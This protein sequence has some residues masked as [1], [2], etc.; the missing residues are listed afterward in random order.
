[1][2]IR[3]RQHDEKMQRR[4]GK[5]FVPV[6]KLI[7]YEEMEVDSRDCSGGIDEGKVV[8]KVLQHTRLLHDS[9]YKKKEEEHIYDPVYPGN[10]GITN[11][12]LH[13][14]YS[15]LYSGGS[16]GSAF[17]PLA[18]PE[19]GGRNQSHYSGREDMS[20]PL[21]P[22]TVTNFNSEYSR[23][24]ESGFQLPLSSG[25]S[26]SNSSTGIGDKMT[27]H[28]SN[29]NNYAVGTNAPLKFSKISPDDDWER[30][31]EKLNRRKAEMHHGTQYMHFV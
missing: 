2:D 4:T 10:D 16:S 3:R 26:S 31:K 24:S 11:G 25:G 7:D 9:R 17:V 28:A 6:D 23:R 30:E 21:I 15:S 18:K 5:S 27:S 12:G 19:V 13:N 29:K 22:Q 14:N 20:S 1:M 8:E